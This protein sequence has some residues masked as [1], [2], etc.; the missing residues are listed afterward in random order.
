MRRVPRVPLNIP[1]RVSFAGHWQELTETLDVSPLGIRF[2][3]SRSIEPGSKILMELKMPRDLRTH[4]F[5]DDVYVVNAFVLYESSHDS[6][7]QVVAEFI[8]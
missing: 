8:F 5:D 3:L 2:R 1:V 4:S 7:R 6:G